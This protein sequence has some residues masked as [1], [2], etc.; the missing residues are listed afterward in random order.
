MRIDW[1]TLALQTANA[2]VLIWLLNRFLFRPVSE[3]V[4][5]RQTE[6]QRLIADATENQNQVDAARAALAAEQRSIAAERDKLLA[7]AHTAAHA[8]RTALLGRTSEEIA[9]LH[10]EG[11]A[12]IVRERVEM[13]KTLIDRAKHLSLQIARHLLDRI[14]PLAATDL[15]LPEL[16][17]KIRSLS[18]QELGAFT[19]T[20]ERIE[21]VT[22]TP[23]HPGDAE[24]TRGIISK[25]IGGD[26]PLVFRIDAAVIAGI[27]IHSQ[28]AIIRNSWRN[29]LD[30]ICEVLKRVDKPAE[31]PR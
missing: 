16:C 30:R 5:R 1:W 17:Q 26:P 15:F 12:A 27:E 31:E 19:S 20:N 25:A 3:I 6:A 7:D 9:R 28:R 21:I 11:V 22:A 18:A 8:E 23:L 29:D 10:A 2:V 13:E 24:R 4:T 14:A